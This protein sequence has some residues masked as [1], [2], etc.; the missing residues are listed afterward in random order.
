MVRNND[1]YLAVKGLL[2]KFL[3]LLRQLPDDV[4]AIRNRTTDQLG[5][6]ARA[7]D[8]LGVIEEIRRILK[9]QFPTVRTWPEY[10]TLKKLL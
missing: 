6:V 8:Q 7:A 9:Q 5:G 1:L 10:G 3:S 2:M 4:E